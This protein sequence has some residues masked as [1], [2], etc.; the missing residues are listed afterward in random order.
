ML[1]RINPFEKSMAFVWWISGVACWWF[2]RYRFELIQS[3]S[4]LNKSLSFLFER[5]CI[6]GR[7]WIASAFPCTDQLC[8]RCQVSHFRR[9][10]LPE[11]HGRDSGGNNGLPPPYTLPPGS[12]GWWLA[13]EYFKAFSQFECSSQ[14]EDQADN[15]N[16]N[17]NVMICHWTVLYNSTSNS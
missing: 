8:Y 1:K 7:D 2:T 15:N 12:S 16:N 13:V 3:S 4:G 14:F 17:K 5:L 9:I 6:I 10:R 11:L